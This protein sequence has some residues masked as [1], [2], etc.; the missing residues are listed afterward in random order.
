MQINL[1]EKNINKIDAFLELKII[2]KSEK[3]STKLIETLEKINFFKDSYNIHLDY[4]S[5]LN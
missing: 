5:R 4:E 1:Y 2:Q 3:L